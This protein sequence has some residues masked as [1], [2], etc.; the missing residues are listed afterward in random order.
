MPPSYSS[1]RPNKAPRISFKLHHYLSRYKCRINSD[2]LFL[3]PCCAHYKVRIYFCQV[4]IECGQ[5]WSATKTS[6]LLRCRRNLL[7]VV[8]VP[9]SK[10]AI[11]LIL[12]LAKRKSHLNPW[13]DGVDIWGLWLEMGFWAR[14]NDGMWVDLNCISYFAFW[15]VDANMR[16]GWTCEDLRPRLIGANLSFSPSTPCNLVSHFTLGF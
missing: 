8:S 14:G 10:L 11:G 13:Q 7:H 5:M 6:K 3:V 4:S 2:C 16:C 1:W 12:P 15:A 9:I